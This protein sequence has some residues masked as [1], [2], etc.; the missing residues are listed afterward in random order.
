MIRNYHTSQE[1][2]INAGVPL[3]SILSFTL[4]ALYLNELP[5]D[6]IY[7]ITSYTDDTTLYSKYDE[8]SHLMQQPELASELES[9][10]QDTVERGRKWLVYFNAKI[11]KFSHFTSQITLVQ[12]MWK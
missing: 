1:H 9:D 2:P 7:N 5:D 3:G 8:A 12:L 4:F 11:I 10:H 6:A